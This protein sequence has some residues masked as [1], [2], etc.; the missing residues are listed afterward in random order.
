MIRN[1]ERAGKVGRLCL[2]SQIKMPN[3]PRKPTSRGPFTCGYQQQQPPALIHY[4]LTLLCHG[5]PQPLPSLLMRCD[6]MPQ[7]LFPSLFYPQPS[8]LSVLICL[9]I[10]YIILD[11]SVNCSAVILFILSLANDP[12][13][14]SNMLKLCYYIHL[15]QVKILE[16]DN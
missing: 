1:I 15:S 12:Y 13:F 5:P 6:A 10:S 2:G 3:G 8:E 11:N 14:C 16:F 9:K 4:G 7:L